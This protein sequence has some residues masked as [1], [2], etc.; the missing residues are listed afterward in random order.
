[1]IHSS[2]HTQK[3]TFL[4]HLHMHADKTFTHNT[5]SGEKAVVTP[6]IILIK[7]PADTVCSHPHH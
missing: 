2:S 1:M 5:I 3:Y 7:L 6:N 4:Q